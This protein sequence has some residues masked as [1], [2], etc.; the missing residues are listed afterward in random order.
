MSL[1]GA[2]TEGVKALCFFLSRQID[3]QKQL[4]QKMEALE[5]RMRALIARYDDIMKELERAK[6]HGGSASNEVTNWLQEVESMK[7]K[8]SD[9]Q[10]NFAEQ[11]NYQKRRFP[12]YYRRRK[13]S[14]K[15]SILI[16]QVEKLITDGKFEN[17]VTI[18]P[19]PLAS[20]ALPTVP[21]RAKTVE[22][23]KQEILDCILGTE[24]KI[25]GVHGMGGVGKTTIMRNIHNDLSQQSESKHFDCFIWINV[26]NDVDVNKLQ[27]K[28][29]KQLDISMK[30]DDDENDRASKIFNALKRRKKFLLILDDMWKQ[31]DLDEVGIPIPSE[32]NGC[33]VVLTTRNKG[34]CGQMQAH[35][36]EVRVLSEEESWEFFK[37]IVVVG[38]VTLSEDIESLARDVAKECCNLPL[39]IKTVGGSMCGVDNVRVWKDRLKDLKEANGEFKDIDKVFVALRFSYTQ[40]HDR[41]L[42]SCFLFC[43]LYPEDHEIT[44]NELIDNW[45]CEGLID[46]RGTREEDINKGHTILNQLIKVSML[47]KCKY[48]GRKIRVG[49]ED[50]ICIKMHDLIRDMAIDITRAENP[51]SLIYAGRQLVD[52]PA[53]LPELPE[54][55]IRISLMHNDIEVLSG[56]PNCQH[57]LTL[58]I[59]YNPLQKISPDS[60]FNHMCSLRVLNLS[61]TNI[62]SLPNSV[63]NLKNLR[64][65]ILTWCFGLE[66]VPS[67]EKLE[68]L[69]VLDLNSTNIRELPSG[70]EAMVYLQRLDLDSTKQ[71]RVFPA[72]IIPRLS[73]L[74][75]L[76]MGGSRWKWSSKTG[77][78]AGIEEIMNSTRMAILNI[79]FEELSDFLQHAKSN[80]WQTMKRFC[81]AVGRSVL[82]APMVECSCVEIGGCDLIGEEN[83]LLLP[84]TTQRL[85]ISYCQISSLW[86]FTRLLHKSKLYHCEIEGCDNM[87]YLMAEEEPLLPDIKK[88]EIINI[89]EL[90]VLC[91]GIPSPDALKSLESLHVFHC[92]KLK[93]LLPARLLQ[94]LRCL[95]SIK[96]SG[97]RQM[98]EIVGEEEEMGITREDDNNAMLI[99]SQLQSLTISN[100]RELKGICSR[101]LICNALETIDIGGCPKLKKLPFSVDNLPCALKEIKGQKGWWDA[102]EWGHPQTRAHFDSRPKM[103]R[104]RLE[105]LLNPYL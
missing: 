80:K 75:E 73:H 29:A 63:S 104:E 2:A 12:N 23:T 58:F 26:S 55:A 52:I 28:I 27:R 70:V 105:D 69:R 97:C 95:K 61:S 16:D 60:Y 43:S 24:K 81:L 62:E 94:Q 71:L 37:D 39:A 40:L 103:L 54:D 98:K 79:Q 84:D 56:E 34:I 85:V 20:N 21:I 64:A 76:T 10:R 44:A 7:Q 66:E 47:E 90:L 100:L 5:S 87:D 96:V 99:L 9:T 13:I 68:K 72:G 42:Q 15:S 67:L 74:E 36:I 30:E 6:L 88:L 78:G 4:K 14:K 86:H 3:Y 92:K 45:I 32:E 57:L 51:R 77:E 48:H 59:Q 50:E 1:D 38:G 101:V 65:L 49:D 8:V 102:V 18:E 46:K 91:K 83:R 41:V 31:F 35:A 93:Y 25:I 33:K 11:K 22:L 19:L 82:A 89:P 17:G 53:E